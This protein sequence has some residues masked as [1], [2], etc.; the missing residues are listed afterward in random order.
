[1]ASG[2]GKEASSLDHS[3]NDDP[4]GRRKCQKEQKEFVEEERKKKERKGQKQKR[5]RKRNEKEK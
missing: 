2:K 5:K 1:M 4:K 3:V